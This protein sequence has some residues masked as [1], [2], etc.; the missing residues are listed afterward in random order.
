MG[1]PAELDLGAPIESVRGVG[2]AR[3]AALRAAGIGT[4]GAL[5]SVLP[6]A[7][8]DRRTLSTVRDILAGGVD[9]ATLLVRLTSLSR[10]RIRR[11]G[12]SLVEGKAVDSTGELRAVWFNRPYLADQ[13]DP[14]SEVLLHGRIRRSAR[15]VELVNASVTTVDG[16]AP[17]TCARRIVP[18]YPRVGEV[19]P[20]TVSRLVAAVLGDGR[21]L[22]ISDPIPFSLRQ[23]RGLPSLCEALIGLHR[24]LPRA[25][26]ALLERGESPEHQRLAYGELL[27]QQLAL[28]RARRA[29]RALPKPHR[30]AIDD[31]LRAAVRSMLSF[32]LTGAQQRVLG[33]LVADLE[34]PE[35]MLRLLQ[36]DVGCGK[37]VV[38][39]LLLAVALENRL[40]GAFMAPTELL[41][42]QHFRTLSRLYDGRYRVDL[43]TGSTAQPRLRQRIASGES[44]L[45]VGTHSLIT[46]G[47]DFARLGL[48]VIDEQHRFGVSQR[49]RLE[50]K[51][52]RPDVLVMTATPIPRSLAMTAYGDLDLSVIDELPPGRRPP[53]TEL[54]PRA[55]RRRVFAAVESELREGGQAFVVFP[56]IADSDEIDA[57]AVEGL[58]EEYRRRFAAYGVSVATGQTSPA[59]RER[60]ME[61]FAAG[62]CRVL[63]ATTVI[64]V[65]VDVEAAGCMVIESAERFGLA[66]LHQLRGRVGRGSG[67]SA[68]WAVH[69]GLTD[70]ARRRLEVFRQTSDGFRI[71]EAD[72]EQRGPGELLGTRQAGWS[73]LRIADPV[74]DRAL[75][76]AAR[77]DARD[78]LEEL[79]DELTAGQLGAS[80]A[81]VR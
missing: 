72:L 75:L 34:R 51:G 14:A 48:A 60:S 8:Q 41:A 7:Y 65:G 27:L 81:E 63:L 74:R 54:V 52:V 61:A 69:G 4:V 67:R 20:S 2:P 59:E 76:A 44:D 1:S 62:R 80:A 53:A 25:D 50:R 30:Y 31:R 77:D 17:R 29:H 40:Q 6:R 5:L 55:R 21:G 10:R 78:L 58:G 47:L 11:R 13:V 46:E 12:A 43:L 68:C 33:E 56:L 70:A 18:V 32:P 71:A 42:E 22:P 35:P 16:A 36:G 15:G 57:G 19:A 49:R 28:A 39:G 66:Q 38:A 64:E 26:A 24:P 3:A 23:K 9:S 37:T 79:S 45:V 73:E